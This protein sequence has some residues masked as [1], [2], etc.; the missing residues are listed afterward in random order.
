M[1]GREPGKGAKAGEARPGAEGL[2]KVRAQ[3][4][5]SLSAGERE[6]ADPLMRGLGSQGNFGIIPLG[7]LAEDRVVVRGM[8]SGTDSPG[9]KAQLSCLCHLGE[10][11]SPLSISF[12]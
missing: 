8:G 2:C 1:K 3:L 11:L 9:A 10:I 12:F 6:G 5:P 7:T 4:G